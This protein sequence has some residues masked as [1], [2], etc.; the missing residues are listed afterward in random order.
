VAAAWGRSS[1]SQTAFA[2][3]CCWRAPLPINAF[4]PSVADAPRQQV[5]QQGVRD[6]N[7]VWGVVLTV[8]HRRALRVPVVV[9]VTATRETPSTPRVAVR[10]ISGC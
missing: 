9:N 4:V 8:V 7:A 1:K 2:E 5:F 3:L 6:Q 10:V